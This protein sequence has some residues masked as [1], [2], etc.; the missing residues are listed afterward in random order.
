[1]VD[2][3]TEVVTEGLPQG[4]VEDGVGPL[5]GESACH[6]LQWR[7]HG[8]QRMSG[9]HMRAELRNQPPEEPAGSHR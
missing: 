1:M 7:G 9:E 6:A 4:A 3:R 5:N 2:C 8:R